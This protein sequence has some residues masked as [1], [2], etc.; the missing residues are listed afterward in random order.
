M[1]SIEIRLSVLKDLQKFLEQFIE[2]IR[3]KSVA[4]N[5]RV[6]QLRE[7]GVPVQIAD[8]YEANY[9]AQNLQHLR[10]LITNIT[11]IHL[12]YINADIAKLEQPLTMRD[13]VGNIVARIIGDRIWDNSGNWLYEFRGNRIYDSSG[14]WRFELRGD[15]VYDTAGNWRFELRDDRI[16]DTSGN[17][18]GS[19]Y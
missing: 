9:G 2:D 1:Q 10:T 4:Y 19:E 12:P 5:S 15:R 16:Y 11:D 3:E 6:G 8:Y 18:L 14:N 7:A 17:W 13:T